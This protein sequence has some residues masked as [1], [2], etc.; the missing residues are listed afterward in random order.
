MAL[1]L[2]AL[3]GMVALVAEYGHGL[4]VKAENQRIAD[5]AA[6]AGA[7][8]YTATKSADDMDAAA[9]RVAALNGIAADGIEARLV[10]SPRGNGNKGVAVTV[11]TPKAL[12]LAPIIGPQ[13]SIA[14]GATAIA[15]VSSVTVP[16]CILAL[17]A[18]ETG[19]TLSGGT[20]IS[21]ADCV[22]AS[23]STVSVPCGTQLT[24]ATVNYDSATAPSNPCK[25]IQAPSG[26]TLTITRTPTA[27]PLTGHEGV[28]ATTGRLA[29]VAALSAPKVEAPA[30]GGD[31]DFAWNTSST[32][33][34]ATAIGCSATFAG[35]TW[36]L[37][38][39]SGGTYD[40]NNLTMGGGLTLDFNSGASAST[41]YNFKGSIATAGTAYFG[42]GT[43][44]IAQGIKTGGGST[45]TFGAGT[46][47]IGP[48]TASCSNGSFSICHLGTT[49]TFGGPST[50][51]IA[52]GIHA[53][54]GA[55]LNLG[56]GSINSYE[57]G[58][59]STGSFAISVAGGGKINLADAT[60]SANLFRLTGNITTGGGSCLRL[61]VAAQHDIKGYI[62]TAG[63]I[64]LGAGLY[65]VTD[66][67][68]FGG[69][70][71]G[72]VACGIGTIGVYGSGVTLTLGGATLPTS[73]TCSGQAF[74]IGSGYS[75][76]TLMAPTSGSTAK[77][78][79]I[80]PTGAKS[81]AGA[82]LAQGASNVSIS[83]AFYFP[84]GPIVMSGGSGVSG[85]GN[86]L[87]LIGSRV[88]LSG[89]A[90]AASACISSS[91]AGGPVVLVQ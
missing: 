70:G 13:S 25:G 74:C 22:V 3:L 38:C 79:V 39:P 4:V 62:L 31:I 19:V 44:T 6:F 41:T 90:K 86:C 35:S 49:L 48:S 78:A 85:S 81:T 30:S 23:N 11:T 42:P 82:T 17:S 52:G 65:T 28:I 20:S 68:S 91:T 37:T 55:T 8:A 57:I 1:I 89:G 64:E 51:R 43:Y 75:N 53:N 9:I 67:A 45:T 47:I 77:I 34:Q 40:F 87:Q 59:N 50:F 60:G 56:S 69:S 21:A 72:N 10:A 32:Q 54:G 61:P 63:G 83:G 27:D 84:K 88:T 7:L 5:L 15:E 18:A 14:I 46:F 29:T 66:Y 2:P 58:P 16:G 80:G 24:T 36:T 73:G 33:K 71:G 26:K 76:V 12:I